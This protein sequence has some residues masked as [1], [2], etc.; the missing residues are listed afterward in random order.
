[1][2][3][4]FIFWIIVGANFEAHQTMPLG[5]YA[6]PQTTI[7]DCHGIFKPEIEVI[8]SLKLHVE[9]IYALR[10]LLYYMHILL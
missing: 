9:I 10:E 2:Q 8:K 6:K 1:M 7:R 4:I 5:Q 3:M